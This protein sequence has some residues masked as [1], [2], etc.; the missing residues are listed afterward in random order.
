[1]AP[2]PK[3]CMAKAKSAKGECQAK[4]S[5]KITSARESR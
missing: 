2:L 4:V 3:P 5:R 1:M